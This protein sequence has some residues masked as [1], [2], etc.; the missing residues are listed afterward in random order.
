MAT[1]F[2][3]DAQ[4]GDT[5]FLGRL[6]QCRGDDVAVVVLAVPA[7]LDPATKARMQGEQ[8]PA[9]A[10]VKHQCG[11]GDVARHAVA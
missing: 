11:G 8:Y 1:K 7:E 3:R 10:V 2:G 6:A 9:A 4:T 5:G